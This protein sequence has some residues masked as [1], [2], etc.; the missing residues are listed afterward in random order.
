MEVSNKP[1]GSA[2]P[3]QRTA[4]WPLNRKHRRPA[5]SSLQAVWMFRNI[6]RAESVTSDGRSAAQSLYQ[7]SYPSFILI[8]RTTLIEYFCRFTAFVFISRKKCCE[9][10]T[11]HSCTVA[12][13]LCYFFFSCSEPRYLMVAAFW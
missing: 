9:D 1:Q 4:R 12:K 8:S 7:L 6:L 2:L 3:V 5:G 11:V 10:C 13:L